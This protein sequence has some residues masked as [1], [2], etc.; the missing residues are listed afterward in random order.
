MKKWASLD[1]KADSIS[2]MSV[3][4]AHEK[5]IKGRE[6]TASK[7]IVG[8][9][10]SGVD[11]EHEDLKGVI[12]TNEKEIPNNHIDDDK[13]GYV[14]DINGWN[15]LG[16]TIHENLEFTRIL[17]KG[18]DGSQTYKK[19][20]KMYNGEFKEANDNLQHYIF[21]KEKI[22]IS[23]SIIKLQIVDDKDI[24]LKS[25]ENLEH[26]A[27]ISPETKKHIDFLRGFLSFGPSI[28]IIIEQLQKG[29]DYFQGQ[30][31]Y[32]LNM[33]FNGRAS[34]SDDPDN[35][36]DIY[37]G[38]NNVMGPSKKEIEHGT[39]VAGI[40]AAKRHN[41][42]G[43]DGIA[44][45]VEIMVLRA[46]PDGDEYDKDIALSIKYAVDN[47]AKVINTSFGKAFSPHMDKVK[48]AI[49]YAAKKDVLIV[50]AAGN[51][52]DNIDVV[53]SYPTDFYE[54]KEIAD[55]MITI[56]AIT[57]QFGD[58]LVA[59]FS[60]YGKTNV[61]VFAPGVKIWS[62]T[63]NNKYKFLDGTSMA[64]PQVTGVATLVRSLYPR[65]KASQ[66]KAIIMAS[67][68]SINGKIT[69]GEKKNVSMT[70]ISK[71]GK[72]VN[73][74]NAILMADKMNAGKLKL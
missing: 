45:N 68:I 52:T 12:W 40:I 70:E 11:I 67:G 43:L 1:P 29:L 16:N 36:D 55:N 60:N 23:D 3:E 41:N 4:L 17:K 14:D 44:D 72:I 26:R 34:L 35:F 54:G 6:K 39:H 15:F 73:L 38:N 32:H 28:D 74:Y 61:D 62:T 7:V 22:H 21:L 37:Y 51:D 31:D 5:L 53:E 71:T 27:G 69:V 57:P 59:P 19:A 65:L 13:N 46:V 66:V 58:N 49:L 25:L 42:I 48:E 30:V 63:P 9:I 50:N 8:V 20:Q 33:D 47:G 2:G 64:A 10:D 24:T 18:D 56:G